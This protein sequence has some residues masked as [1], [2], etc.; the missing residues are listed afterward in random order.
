M[1]ACCRHLYPIGFGVFPKQPILDL[2][3][4]LSGRHLSIVSSWL[5]DLFHEGI[6]AGLL[7]QLTMPNLSFYLLSS[8]NLPS[9][10]QPL[11]ATDIPKAGSEVQPFHKLTQSPAQVLECLGISILH[12]IC[13]TCWSLFLLTSLLISKKHAEV[14]FGSCRLLA[15]VFSGCWESSI[16]KSYKNSSSFYS[17]YLTK[18]ALFCWT[19]LR[20][21]GTNRVYL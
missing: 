12:P 7:S 14:A 10:S 20:V 9:W 17:H 18:M 4:L 3:Y 11:T 6:L 2:Q 1:L 8:T 19:H 5:N 15:W 21:S 16:A 13:L